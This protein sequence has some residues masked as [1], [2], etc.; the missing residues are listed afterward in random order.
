MINKICITVDQICDVWTIS[1]YVVKDNKWSEYYIH[2]L[3]T[4]DFFL[5]EGNKLSIKVFW[6]FSPVHPQVCLKKH[7]EKYYGKEYGFL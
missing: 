5:H 6:R 7:S 1:K 4:K 3:E 2:T